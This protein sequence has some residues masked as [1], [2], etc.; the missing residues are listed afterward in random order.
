MVDLEGGGYNK[1]VEEAERTEWERA[2]SQLWEWRGAGDGSGTPERFC[3]VMGGIRK[4]G[5]GQR[6][7]CVGGQPEEISLFSGC[8]EHF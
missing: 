4:L 5:Q 6:M 2:W 1:W 8:K 7:A 3:E